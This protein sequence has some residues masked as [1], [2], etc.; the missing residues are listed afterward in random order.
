MENQWYNLDE[1]VKLAGENGSLLTAQQLQ[2]LGEVVWQNDFG[3][4]LP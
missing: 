4:Y 2:K 3:S 1:W